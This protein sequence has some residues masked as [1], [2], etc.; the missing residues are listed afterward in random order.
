MRPFFFKF[1]SLLS[2]KDGQKAGGLGLLTYHVFAFFF[3]GGVGVCCVL[4]LLIPGI[5]V[6]C[7]KDLR[8]WHSNQ[9][10]VRKTTAEIVTPSCRE[11]KHIGQ[12]PSGSRRRVSPS[13]GICLFDLLLHPANPVYTCYLAPG[14]MVARRPTDQIDS[15]PFVVGMITV[16]KQ[17]HSEYTE[18]FLA[19]CGQYVRSLI[20]ASA[21]K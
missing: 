3:Q 5:F 19:C 16:L 4:L 13:T 15:A 12:S 2:S 1:L 21:T 6:A 14:T 17:F 7:S 11:E 20:E 18:Q 10:L 9:T 8:N